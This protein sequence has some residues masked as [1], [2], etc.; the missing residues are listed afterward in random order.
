MARDIKKEIKQRIL[1]IQLII[2]AS[3]FLL[4]AKSFEIQILKAGELSKKAEND[5]S[6]HI[7]L[8]GDRGRIL[9]RS[10]NQLATSIEAISITACPMMIDAPAATAKKLAKALKIRPKSLQ[11]KLSS[12]RMFTWIARKVTPEK[13]GEIRKL[14]LKGIYFESDS[15]RYY[16]NWHLAAQ[17]IGFTGNEDSGL[18]GLEFKYNNV[19]EGQAIKVKVKRD[20]A[21][22]IL[23]FDKKKRMALSGNSL[24]L[25][26]DKK[27][28]YFSEQTLE[29][30][31]EEY[32][33]NSGMALVMR[34][35][36]GELLSIAHY[37]EFNPNNFYQ[38]D[39][40]IFRNRSVTD[41]FEPGSVMKV[42]TAAAALEKG[43]TPRSIFFCE[44]GTYAI[45]RGRFT[46]R[47]T[48]PHDWLSMNQIIKYSSNIGTVKIVEAIGNRALYQCLSGFGFGEKTF[49]GCPGETTGKL[50]PYKKWSR[51]DAGAISY[52][53]GVSVSALQLIS[54]ISAI[55]N[56]GN[57]MK[58]MLVKKVISNSGKN[59]RIY[60]PERVRKVISGKTAQQV[61]KM[62]SLV[63][64]EDG[65][66]SKAALNRYTVCGKTGTAQKALKDKKGYAKKKYISVFAG[67]AP[68]DNPEL[69]V[70]VVIDEPLKKY[71]G[72][73]VAAPAVR[74]IMAESF[75]Y[76]N[77]PPEKN[78]HLIA[79]ASTGKK[80]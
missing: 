30:T 39:R 25:T 36:T 3:I 22:R 76:L 66:G 13:A 18:E 42:F 29:K 48:R 62:M 33:A 7:T 45:G 69:A 51:I 8:K 37:P 49:V 68:Y 71:Y 61:K 50:A 12:K 73:D 60:Q 58:P 1:A 20:G 10:Q 64:K 14:N 75:N 57:L 6:K 56:N 28:Q 54:G 34:P 74:S 47:D 59:V 78:E 24:V 32:D 23:N 35:R 72:S 53:Q 26:I 16:P 55:A 27:I 21:G 43:L 44:K 5:Y 31:V 46:I 67:F 77:V 52:G 17:V 63:V 9:D 79:L 11:E 15:K 40:E 2:V 38:Y 65:T 70:L 19:L 80:S 4:G 41:A